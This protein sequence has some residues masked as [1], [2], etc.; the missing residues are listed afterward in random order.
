[1]PQRSDLPEPLGREP[2]AVRDAIARGVTR[3]RLRSSDLQRAFH[4]TRSI[5][6]D[7]TQLAD[8]CRAY[9]PRMGEG[10]AFSHLT[11]A[12]LYAFPLPLGALAP[13]DL[14]VTTPAPGRAPAGR[15]VLG[16]RAR[17]LPADIVEFAGL[18]LVSPAVAWCQLAQ[19]LGVDDTVA[20]A[21]WI[22]TGNP[23]FNV[24]PLADFDELTAAT[25]SRAGTAGQRTRVAALPLVRDGPVSRPESL[26]RLLLGRAGLPEP[27]VN[28]RCYGDD[29]QELGMPDLAW[30]DY[31]TVGQYEGDHHRGQSQFRN[32]IRRDERFVDH[33]WKVVK[34]TADDLFRRPVELAERFGRRLAAQGWRGRIELRHLGHFDR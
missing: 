29:G 16:H 10:N 15:G 17:L 28:A 2:F 12:E 6:L 19:K 27:L 18:P 4:G 22:V 7:L 34:A 11:A 30:P 24:L 20:V 1:M 23:Y 25:A 26:L 9:L 3:D 13:F 32:D 21:D 14:H 5:G 31:R 8:R 33:D